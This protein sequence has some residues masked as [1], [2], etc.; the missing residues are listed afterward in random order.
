MPGP[1]PG[2][3]DNSAARRAL[4]LLPLR[5]LMDCRA[6]PG[7]DS[8]EHQPSIGTIAASLEFRNVSDVFTLR[9]FGAAVSFS[10]KA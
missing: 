2:I 5:C 1:D 4:R 9:T 10:T 8:E 7:N 6:K 3:H